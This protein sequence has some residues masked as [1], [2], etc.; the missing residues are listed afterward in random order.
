MKLESYEELI[1]WQKA[2][3]LDTEIYR[4]QLRSRNMRRTG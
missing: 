2:L 3:E 1:V 4:S